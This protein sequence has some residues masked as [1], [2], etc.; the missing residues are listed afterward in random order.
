MSAFSWDTEGFLLRPG[1]AAPPVVC[2]AWTASRDEPELLHARFDRQR[3]LDRLE[4]GLKNEISVGAHI[5]HDMVTLM[6]EEPDLWPVVFDAYEQDRV[7]DLLMAQKL[8]DIGTDVWDFGLRKKKGEYNLGALA[9][10]HLKIDME[11]DLWR[12]R[13]GQFYDVPID[14]WKERALQILPNE[15]PQGVID[16]PKLDAR[17]GFDIS[18]A[19]SASP[20][21]LLVD[22]YNQSRAAFWIHLMITHGL[23]TDPAAARALRLKVEAELETLGYELRKLG[24]MRLDGS[25][26]T[27]VA[28]ERMV[29]ACRAK[30]IEPTMTDGG[31]KGVPQ[32]ALDVDSCELSGD[33][34]LIKYA[35]YTSLDSIHG[36][37]P[38]LEKPIIQSRFDLADTGRTTCD[39]G[40]KV[41]T[42]KKKRAASLDGFQLQN[43]RK[44][45]GI[46]ECFVPRPGTLFL[47]VDYGQMEL[48]TWAQC[49]LA[50]LGHSTMAEALNRKIDVHV[51]FAARFKQWD[52][53]HALKHRREEPYKGGRQMAKPV[54]FGLPGGLGWRTLK[55]FAYQQY[56]VVLTDQEAKD[57]KETWL[58]TWP[59]SKE[60][61]RFMNSLIHGDKGALTHYRS[62]RLRTGVYFPELCNGAFQGLAGD[63]GKDAGF[64]IAKACY[65][66]RRSVLYGSRVV[67]FVHDEFILEVPEAIAHECALEVVSLMEAAGRR[68]CPDV[69]PRAEPALMRRWMKAA[70]PVYVNDRLVPWEPKAK[71]A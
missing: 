57:A 2:L 16:Y 66:D 13:Y 24:L 20:P 29:E 21:E 43:P 60:Y 68:W 27:K 5:A 51:M 28:K 3:M 65:V 55:T 46:R 69:P 7:Y 56:E 59:E 48:H 8:I 12:L 30:G 6:R 23:T 4:H 54:N 35:R 32:V 11:K 52:Y 70:E 50:W 1:Q 61:F 53:E 15:N 17:A 25:K 41:G 64:Y 62:N 33:P 34:V 42:G 14:R 10:R 19:Q 18:Y 67:N 22:V 71:A 39:E 38:K 26:D 63:C 40:E 31:E 58:T 45:P 37:I 36:S 9:K 47:S 49:C 44:E